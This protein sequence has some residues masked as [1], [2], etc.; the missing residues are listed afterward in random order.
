[1]RVLLVEPA[2]HKSWGANNQYIGLLKVAAYHK[3]AGDTVE[4]IRAYD[5]PSARPDLI[6][7][8]SMFTYWYKCVWET[9]QFYR[10]FHPGVPIWLGGIYATICPEHAARSGVDKVIA[11]EY[12]GSRSLPPDPTVLP[13]K[14][15]FVYSMTSYGCP[16][17]FSY[18]ASHILYGP[19]IHQRPIEEVFGEWELQ[20][21]RGFSTIYVGDDNFLF[22]AEKHALPLL[23]MVVRRGLK[24]SLELPGGLQA[25]HVTPEIATLMFRAG[26]RRVSTSIETVN[27]QVA[28]RMGRSKVSSTDAVANAVRYFDQAGFEKMDINVFFMIGLPYQSIDDIL[29]T[30]AFLARLGV[31]IQPQRWAPIPGT[32]DFQRAGLDKWDLEDLHY[33]SFLAPGVSFSSDDLDFIYKAA[34]FINIG[35]RYTGFDLCGTS[36]M[37]DRLREVLLRDSHSIASAC[38]G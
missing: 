13:V 34:R 1:M 11:G 25:D 5:I 26:F 37:H 32:R 30:F 3:Q 33:K 7:V 9:V 20:K 15:R 17:A 4:Y 12:H 8:T 23:E 24:I 35:R 18:C 14:P 29:D 28:Q 31:W 19:G 36:P 22:N 27:E 10:F 38:V 6:L 16:N 21:R 2:Q